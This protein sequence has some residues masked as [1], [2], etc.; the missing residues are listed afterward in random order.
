MKKENYVKEIKGHT[1]TVISLSLGRTLQLRPYEPIKASVYVSVEIEPGVKPEMDA[2]Y[3][4]L[5][6]ELEEQMDKFAKETEMD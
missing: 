2:L 6:V 3:D 4:Y 1:V 5:I